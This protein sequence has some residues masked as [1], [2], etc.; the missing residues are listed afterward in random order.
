[1]EVQVMATGVVKFFNVKSRFGFI[2]E[3]STNIDY[4]FYVGKKDV[5]FSKDDRVVFE[6]REAKRGPEA[7]NVKKADEGS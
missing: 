1:M 7:I 4:Y 6:I 5:N 3:D 2:S